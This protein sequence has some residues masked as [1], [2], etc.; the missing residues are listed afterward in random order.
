MATKNPQN[1]QWF[2]ITY[3][4]NNQCLYTYIECTYKSFLK[5]LSKFERKYFN[6]TWHYCDNPYNSGLL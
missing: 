5:Y 4:Y 3:D 6:V 1:L 2:C